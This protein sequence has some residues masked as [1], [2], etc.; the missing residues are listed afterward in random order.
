MT[1]TE[2]ISLDFE[3]F[4]AADIG[5]MQVLDIHGS[6]TGW[7]WEFAGP[8][9]PKTEA[10]NNRF[11]RERLLKSA[12]VEQAQVNGR[13]WK[14]DQDE[15]A[16]VRAKN[17]ADL[18]ERIVGWSAVEI[19]GKPFPFSAENATEFLSH[20]KRI[21]VLTQAMEFVASEKSFTPRSA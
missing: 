18:V 21:G 6:P 2:S 17:I 11:A 12:Q 7:V 16:E 20:P 4:E 10:L 13:K 8:G 9:H 5:K 3:A 15:P 14:A 19:G 1:K